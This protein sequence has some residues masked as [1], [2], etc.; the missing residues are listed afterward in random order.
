MDF[1][2]NIYIKEINSPDSERT[3][4]G[5]EKLSNG[6][7]QR[8]I[9]IDGNPFLPSSVLADD[10]PLYNES[11]EA[12]VEEREK[13][14]LLKADDLLKL[15][16]NSTRFEKLKKSF[17]VN[18][19][20]PFIGA[21]MSM[22]SNYSGWTDFLKILR[23]ESDVSEKVLL[24]L[25]ENGEYE[26]AAQEIF[27]DLGEELFN[28][29]L[30]NEFSCEREISGSIHYLPILFP[31]QSIITTN[32]DNILERIYIGKDQGFDS[33]KSG[34]SLDEIMRQIAEGSRLLIKLHGD[35]R[36]VQDR[37][38]TSSEYEEAYMEETNLYKFFGRVLFKGSLLFLGCSLSSDRTIKTMISYVKKEG[39]KSLPRHFAFLEEIK[40]ENKRKAR[41]K[42]LAKANIFPIWYPEKEADVSI[43]A[44]FL[45]LKEGIS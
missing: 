23:K 15:Y 6:T 33:T 19:L 42:E 10:E 9:I 44:L 43:E 36:Q 22:S 16:D 27:E 30:E 41:K 12:W 45:K 4:F 24:Q 5:N 32:F 18:T 3:A 39:A 11:F 37:V 38:L 21:G 17:S 2:E 28:E 31:N 26:T 14:L 40:D 1:L 29:H 35:A 34:K 20:M 25:L 7:I 13:E 8:T